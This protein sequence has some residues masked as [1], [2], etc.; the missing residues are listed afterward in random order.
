MEAIGQLAGGVA[1][2]FNNLLT[3]IGGY[4]Q[5]AQQRI[6]AGPGHEE[7][8]EI[9]HAA[10]RAAQL[11]RQLLAFS[12][13]QQLSPELLDLDEVVK[14]L[15][16]MLVRL[17][18][19]D[20]EIASLAHDDV[21][22]VLADRT[23]LEQV[24]VNL[25]VNARDAMPSGG[26][27]TLETQKVGTY[28]CLVFTDTG[29]GMDA[30]TMARIFEPF[31][32]T[33]EVGEGTG[34]GLATVYGVVTQSG[35][36]VEV[37]SE[38]DLGSTFKVYLP[39]APTGSARAPARAEREHE[40]EHARGTETVLLCEDEP[41]LRRL[42]E[43]ILTQDGYTVLAAERPSEALALASAHPGPIDVLV[44]DVIMPGMPGPEL[45]E[46]LRMVQ[47]TVRVV[48]MSGYTAE[49]IGSH[50]TLP[51]GTAFLQKPFDAS[52]LPRAVREVLDTPAAAGGLSRAAA[53]SSARR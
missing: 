42:A 18:R 44:S 8:V 3:V 4:G 29:S 34:L 36:R 27:L 19:E 2:D 35:G 28:A 47:P 53:T 25:V 32:T 15:M 17:I 6:G 20:I 16:P 22:I 38:P 49:T 41:T 21:P 33:K 30:A 10:D 45:A 39:A 11:T 24:I 9:L 26:T 1:H 12:R 46:H 31:F 43:M 37:Y 23:Q 14:A 13:R 48:F 50:A 40:R 51:R 7:L 5:V 52:S